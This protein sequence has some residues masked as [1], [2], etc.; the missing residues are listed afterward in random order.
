MQA[1]HEVTV[2]TAP[3]EKSDIKANGFISRQTI[4]GIKL[5]VINSADSNRDSV[6]RR[7]IKAII[8]SLTS[9]KFALTEKYDIVIASSGPIT[10]GFPALIAK[11]L[12][13]KKMIF[14]VRDLWPSGGIE[15][16]KIRNKGIKTL[17]L[18]F[19]KTCYN[20][21][22]LVVT[23]SKGMEKDI[24]SRF[25][26]K[27][28]LVVPNACD[29]EL[30]NTKIEWLP[31]SIFIDNKIILYAGSL[32][33]MDNCEY[34]IQ[35]MKLINN[36]K[37]HVVFIGE[38]TER[39]KLVEEVEKSNLNNIHFIGLIPKKDI[40]KWFSV[41]TASFVMFKDFPV[42]QTSSPNKLFDSLAARVPIIQNTTGWI[43]ELIE[44]ENCGINVSPNNA[45]ELAEAILKL[46]DDEILHEKLS[47]NAERVARTIFNRDLLANQYLEEI[48]LLVK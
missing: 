24:N 30:F 25:P 33:F 10:V 8:Y 2:V 4:E 39:K 7:G 20:N 17:A 22:E 46:V 27:R 36:K 40:V 45:K 47:V 35:A 18:L 5:I 34:I 11:W 44:K 21:S 9:C 13:R 29:L 42:L 32:G 3:Y 6:F 37:I 15:L 16:G 31:P 26:G 23:C 28:T 43:K 19:E 48:K 1:G 14:E 38:G 12:R 41:A